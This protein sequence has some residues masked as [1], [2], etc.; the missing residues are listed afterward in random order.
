MGTA[1]WVGGDIDSVVDLA[2]TLRPCPERIGTVVHTVNAQIR[3]LVGDAGWSG[4][5]ATGFAAHWELASVAG[6][7]VGAFLQTAADTL[8]TLAEELGRAEEGLRQ[9]ASEARGVGVRIGEDGRPAPGQ[10]AT[11]AVANYAAERQ[12]YL[13]AAQGFRLLA[14]QTLS[15]LGNQIV[16]LVDHAGD[17]EGLASADKVAFA[18]YLRGIGAIPS[19]MRKRLDDLRGEQARRF[20]QA[21]DEWQ[22]ARD[23]T[24]PGQKMP[25]DVKASRSAALRELQELD[26]QLAAAE[27]D[28][29]PLSELLNV[30]VGDVV[31]GLPGGAGG[32]FTEAA[33]G[34]RMLKFLSDV[35]VIDVAATG[36]GTYFQARDDIDKGEDPARAIAE[37]G[38]ANVAGLAAGAIAGSAV[39]GLAAGIGAAPV[40]AVGAGVLLGGAIGVGV[41]DL[42]YEGFHEHWDEDIRRDGVVK[43]VAEGIGHAGERTGRDLLNM[44]KGI[45]HGATK[46]WHS[47]FG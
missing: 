19:A 41:G 7:A 10:P 23:A 18:D 42:V 27:R 30:D 47:V 39:V 31:G 34:S 46:I 32:A 35:P 5:A 21:R 8:T 4:D 40:V 44:G 14:E 24:P 6:S 17:G 33:D 15:E 2:A 12:Q 38:T 16:D 13:L 43:G 20:A 28:I 22:A 1:S 26:T 9:A 25:A 11:R 29:R 37:D 3:D 45:E 36:L